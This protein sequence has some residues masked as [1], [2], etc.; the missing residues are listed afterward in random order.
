MNHLRNRIAPVAAAFAVV[1]A[2]GAADLDSLVSRSPFSPAQANPGP[3]AAT[4]GLELRGIVVED[5]KASF[6]IYDPNTKSATW[7]AIEEAGHP[8]VVR[9]FDA[10]KDTATVDWNHKSISLPLKQSKVQLAAASPVAVA[11]TGP[12]PV[13]G[14]GQ[15][16]RGN[17][18]GGPVVLFGGA[19]GAPDQ[20]RM[21]AIAEEI[22]RRR[23]LRAQAQQAAE[24]NGPQAP[25]SNFNSRRGGNG[26]FNG[27]LRD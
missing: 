7:V 14:P 24:Q 23:A 25:A 18:G 10:A 17:R 19:N 15:N 5:G 6:N 20:Q 22:R 21:Q 12:T 26:R 2:A 3:A 13:A 11:P 16:V 27:G 8:F 9:S 4:D 1:A